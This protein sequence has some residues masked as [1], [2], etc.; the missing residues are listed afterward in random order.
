MTFSEI[1]RSKKPNNYLLADETAGAPA[2]GP[3]LKLN[4]PEGAVRAAVKKAMASEPLVEVLEEAAT[5]PIW[6]Y[7]QR[8]RLMRFPDDVH[9]GFDAN[10]S[11]TTLSVYSASRVGYSDMGVNRKRVKRL[12]GKITAAI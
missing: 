1:Q 3:A 8:T 7:V 4:A 12:I 10:D 5:A 11:G 9:F 6:R 2:D